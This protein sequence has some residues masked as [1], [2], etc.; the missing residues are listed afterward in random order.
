MSQLSDALNQL[1][2]TGDAGAFVETVVSDIAKDFQ[3]ISALPGVKAFEDWLAQI[4]VNEITKLGFT[5][6]LA[7]FISQAVLDA[8]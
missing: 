2:A 3:I 4:I 5:G 7:T 6:T 8:L 1:K